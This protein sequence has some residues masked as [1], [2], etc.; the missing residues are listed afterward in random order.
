MN[1]ALLYEDIWT[2]FLLLS[3]SLV[4]LY[5]ACSYTIGPD[6]AMEVSRKIFCFVCWLP[7][8]ILSRKI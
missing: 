6:R 3:M 7:C 1:V 5:Y 2:S 4:W 8:Y